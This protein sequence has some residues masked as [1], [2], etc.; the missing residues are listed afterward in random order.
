MDDRISPFYNPYNPS[1]ITTV[2]GNEKVAEPIQR[3]S[4]I[5]MHGMNFRQKVTMFLFQ[6][7]IFAL[8]G[9]GFTIFG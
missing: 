6:M 2:I 8:I 7:G 1:D 4:P 9:I 3:Q 5:Y